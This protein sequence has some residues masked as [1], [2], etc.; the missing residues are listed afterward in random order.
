[1]TKG[2]STVTALSGVLSPGK[3]RLEQPYFLRVTGDSTFQEAHVRN[4]KKEKNR[5]VSPRTAVTCHPGQ[6]PAHLDSK[7]RGDSTPRRAVTRAVTRP[8][9]HPCP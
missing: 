4:K 2:D 3:L 1:M 5:Q 7:K 9:G 8:G 6:T